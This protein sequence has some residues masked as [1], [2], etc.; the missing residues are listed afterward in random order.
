[1]GTAESIPIRLFS[2]DEIN[3]FLRLFAGYAI[4]VYFIRESGNHA[5]G[6]AR[7]AVTVGDE[8]VYVAPGDVVL[9]CSRLPHGS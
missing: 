1:M 4:M 9:D 2:L 8:E 5:M 6:R 3:S 7:R